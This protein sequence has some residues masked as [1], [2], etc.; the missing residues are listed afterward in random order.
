MHWGAAYLEAKHEF[1]ATLDDEQ[2]ATF[3]AM[4]SMLEDLRFW[5]LVFRGRVYLLAGQEASDTSASASQWRNAVAEAAD[6]VGRDLYN[7]ELSMQQATY[8]S[9]LTL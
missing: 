6:S 9:F 4:Q 2:L 7:L 5:E 3:A 8:R 1:E